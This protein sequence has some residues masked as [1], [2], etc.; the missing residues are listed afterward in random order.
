MRFPRLAA[1]GS[2]AVFASALLASP[3]QA[4]TPGTVASAISAMHDEALAYA[5]YQAWAVQADTVPNH[6]VAILL[7]LVA[8]QERGEHFSELA[9]LTNVI[10]SSPTNL[11]TTVEDENTE[12]TS[13]YPGFQAQA[14]ADGDAT[15]A[16]LFAELAID[17][18]SHRTTAMRAYRALCCHDGRPA[19]PVADPVTILQQPAQ[20]SGQT[21]IN[22]RTAMRGEAYASA[23]YLL[24]A[25]QA[26]SEGRSWVGRLFTALSAVELTEHYAA[27]A[28][29]YGLVGAIDANLTAAV[30]AEDGAIATYASIATA[31]TAAGDTNAAALFADIGTDESAHRTL[32]ADALA[33]LGS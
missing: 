23:R 15:T 7:G 19:N 12:A 2:V 22:V 32:F 33:G 1:A 10:G 5:D 24:F 3:A 29:R 17:E 16:E 6:D 13:I 20:T 30:A 9:A 27:L 28:N 26:Y 11:V 14:I 25:Q 8:V 21:L 31:A 18:A 4:T